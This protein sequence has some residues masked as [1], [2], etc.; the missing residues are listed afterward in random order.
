M[1]KP[2]RAPYR[3]GD[4]TLGE[5][6]GD[7]VADY[8]DAHDQRRRARL[9]VPFAHS[10]KAKAALDRFAEAQRAVAK[11]QAAH[12]VGDLWRLWMAERKA[13]KLRNVI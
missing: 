4:F 12:T 7:A 13:D 10:E 9:G 8:R 3:N 11:Q 5:R 1:R 2:N 6:E